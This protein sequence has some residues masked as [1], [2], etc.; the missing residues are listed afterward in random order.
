MS[1]VARHPKPSRE[2]EYRP[3]EDGHI[4]VFEIEPSTN[5]DDPIVGQLHHIP[6]LEGRSD[7]GYITLS[8]AWGPTKPDG[9]HLTAKVTCE[10][11]PLRI[12]SNLHE[13]LKEIREKARNDALD[14]DGCSG[15]QVYQ[16]QGRTYLWVDAICIDQQDTDERGHQVQMMGQIY[17][18]SSM[19]IVWLNNLPRQSEDYNTVR[20]LLLESL[21]DI[22]SVSTWLEDNAMGRTFDGSGWFSRRWVIQE[23]RL[24]APHKRHVLFGDLLVSASADYDLLKRWNRTFVVGP[25]QDHE[26][27]DKNKR[28]LMEELFY[29]RAAECFDPRDRVYA[30][31]AL[32]SD[33]S[34]V[35]VD[36]RQS[37]EQVYTSVATQ[38]VRLARQDHSLIYKLLADA[39]AETPKMDK[40][41]SWVPD[42]S[43][44]LEIIY[45]FAPGALRNRLSDFEL[46]VL[47]D[48]Q[49]HWSWTSPTSSRAFRVDTA[50]G[51]ILTALLIRPCKCEY[52]HEDNEDCSVCTLWGSRPRRWVPSTGLEAL[53]LLGAQCC[54]NL[55][56][57][58]PTFVVEPCPD[59]SS[60]IPSYRL[61][62]CFWNGWWEK[63]YMQRFQRA[64]QQLWDTDR[65][66]IRIIW[67]GKGTRTQAQATRSHPRP[68]CRTDLQPKQVH[69]LRNLLWPIADADRRKT[70]HRLHLDQPT[71]A[72]TAPE[73]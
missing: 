50:N 18:S 39:V 58:I 5:K 59:S 54:G 45:D 30:L 38:C 67:A 22:L 11:K 3:L 12:T 25:F 55:F 66:T 7:Q 57:G 35:T 49:R 28:T 48:K 36:Y 9:S 19:V 14:D 53:L 46:E 64:Q 34:S 70:P 47:F 2:Y 17:S 8:Y 6:L 24:T 20:R 33:A 41:P 13:G 63:V 73:V 26:M 71:G 23:Y 68:S 37:V 62:G 61:A 10:G 29:H 27:Y 15:P 40:L 31:T 43:H 51:L 42:W 56:W 72:K 60:T 52:Y 4:R 21:R 1:Q 16:R 65:Q 44:R 32:C 69:T